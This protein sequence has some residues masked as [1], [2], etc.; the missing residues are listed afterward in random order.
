[1]GH[2]LLQTL[3][4]DHADEQLY[5]REKNLHT[6]YRK[7]I[8][9]YEDD[10]NEQQWA[11]FTYILKNKFNSEFFFFSSSNLSWTC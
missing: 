4:A 7:V 3:W 8:A 2:K 1:M 6:E 9:G 5:Y 11:E 10:T